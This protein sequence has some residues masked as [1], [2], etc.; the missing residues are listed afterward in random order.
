MDGRT[1]GRTDGKR[2]GGTDGRTDGGIKIIMVDLNT[3]GI[4]QLSQ[5]VTDFTSLS[6]NLHI[7]CVTL[8]QS[9]RFR[10]S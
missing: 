7:I 8:T 2:E 3:Q 5:L 9:S 4:S 10:K 1:D 6:M